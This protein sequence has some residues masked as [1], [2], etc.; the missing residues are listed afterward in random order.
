MLGEY[1]KKEE[2]QRPQNKEKDAKGK[3]RHTVVT[4]ITDVTK[5][6]S[7]RTDCR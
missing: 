7:C 4:I 5:L 3:V 1:I 6:A 2:E